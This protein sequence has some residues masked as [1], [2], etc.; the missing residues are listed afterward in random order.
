MINFSKNAGASL[1][2]KCFGNEIVRTKR[3]QI[4]HLPIDKRL[5]FR[6]NVDFASSSTESGDEQMA[7]EQTGNRQSKNGWRKRRSVQKMAIE[8]VGEKIL[9][10]SICV[11]D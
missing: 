5:S 6:L 9:Y 7:Y 8:W 4:P 3:A 11:I 1:P 10:S 2:K